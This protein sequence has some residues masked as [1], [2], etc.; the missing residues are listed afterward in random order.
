MSG[1]VCC[2]SDDGDAVKML[3]GLSNQFVQHDLSEKNFGCL[4]MK[5]AEQDGG[6][7]PA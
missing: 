2:T 4:A 1:K 6:T 5:M 7:E 3:T